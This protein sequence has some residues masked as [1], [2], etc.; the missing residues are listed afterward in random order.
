MILGG[1]RGLREDYICS[2]VVLESLVWAGVLEARTTRPS[3][4]FP[5][6]MFFDRSSNLYIHFHSALRCRWEP[7]ALWVRDCD[8]KC[9][10]HVSVV[11]PA[12]P[13]E[14]VTHELLDRIIH[15]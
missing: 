9:R 4:T 13:A 2:E 14:P 15:R 11:G 5:R 6:D 8:T 1:P 12:I 3:A 7:P 10:G